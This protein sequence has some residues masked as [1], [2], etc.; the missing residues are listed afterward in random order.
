MLIMTVSNQNIFVSFI[1]L[2]RD[3]LAAEILLDDASHVEAVLR[4]VHTYRAEHD[5]GD[6][7]LVMRL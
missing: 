7:A 5:A 4:N 1:Y 3:A 2:N 6:R